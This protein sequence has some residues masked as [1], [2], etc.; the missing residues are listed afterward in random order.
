MKKKISLLLP[1]VWS[2]GAII[3]VIVFCIGINFYITGSTAGDIAGQAHEIADDAEVIADLKAF[4]ADCILVLGAGLKPDGTP[5]HML[6][7]R[8]DA[9]IMLY[10]EG[11]A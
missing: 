7:D 4:D 11:V 3:W 5:N 9:A 1:V 2:I 6:Q 8:L 10:N